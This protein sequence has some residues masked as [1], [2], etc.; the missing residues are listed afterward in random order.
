LKVEIAAGK[1]AVVS[2]C[3]HTI[4]GEGE[5]FTNAATVKASEVSQT[6]PPVESETTSP[7]KFEPEKVQRLAGETAFVKTKL[8]GKAPL[9]VEYE[10][11]VTNTG[12]ATVH[13][14]EI[15]DVNVAE[16]GTTTPLQP[17][18]KV[19]EKEVVEAKCKHVVENEG[20]VFRN[21]A[22]VTSTEK[23]KVPTKEVEV[24]TFEV[25]FTIEKLQRFQ[26]ETKYTKEAKVGKKGQIVEYLIVVKNT[27][28]ITF[29]L[30][31]FTDEKCGNH[32]GPKAEP[33]GATEK[34]T[35]AEG[36]VAYYTC[37]HELTETG[38]YRNVA[39]VEV[40]PVA[41]PS[42]GVIKPAVTKK[43][44]SNEVEVEV[45]EPTSEVKFEVVKEQRLAGE[46]ES[47]F[48]RNQ[49][50]AKLNQTVLYRITVTNVSSLRLEFSPLSDKNC[51]NI[52]PAGTTTLE[53][54]KSEKFTCEHLLTAYGEWVNEALITGTHEGKSRTKVSN[55]VVV[56]PAPTGEAPGKG[57]VKAQCSIAESAIKLLGVAR[58]KQRPFTARIKS[59]GIKQI[60]FYID[61]HKLKTM[62]AS[63]ARH[64][65]F[66]IK[67][68][69][70]T[71][72]YGAHR[73]SVKTVMKSA[74]CGRIAR[75]AVFVHQRS[76]KRG[77]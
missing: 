12:K 18:V 19:G 16:C 13:V 52:S 7:E 9:T 20:E 35:L 70:R 54:G 55:P 66:L 47:A 28:H 34:T 32:K 42:P 58:P 50:N 17:E 24:E 53:P 8:V 21:A 29:K 22:T 31:T 51:T 6:S 41:N 44:E 10:I 27:G 36:E 74:A 37:E 4:T 1:E 11:R 65:F 30:L 49:I 59:L 48:T 62:K 33:E 14:K 77:A 45:K 73:L 25:E 69:P 2:T 57:V 75:S 5:K 40:E 46:P 64:G 23:A 26:G 38:I 15:A 71:L 61:G 63:Q 39:E 56:D 67:I 43:K 68:D 72:S 76:S 3:E 60:T